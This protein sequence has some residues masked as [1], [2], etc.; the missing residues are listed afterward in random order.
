MARSVAEIEVELGYV[1][2]A[3]QDLLRTGVSVSRPGMSYTRADLAQLRDL[4]KDLQR[5]IRR[6][7]SGQGPTFVTQS[8]NAVTGESGDWGE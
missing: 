8:N 7:S 4:R 3:I 6:K 5:E 2:Q 1:N